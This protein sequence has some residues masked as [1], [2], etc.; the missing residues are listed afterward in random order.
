MPRRFVPQIADSLPDSLLRL[1]IRLLDIRPMIWRRVLVP[2]SYGLQ[3]LHGV[4]F[5]K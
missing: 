2:V 1:K 5:G 3:E 4:S